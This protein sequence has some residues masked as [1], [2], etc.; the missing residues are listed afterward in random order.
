MDFFDLCNKIPNIGIL[1][2]Y[3]IFIVIIPYFLVYSG[4]L[5]VLKFYMPIIVALAH[6]LTRLDEKKNIFKGL[7]ELNPK[8]FVPFLSSNF[9]NIFALFGILWQSIE[10]SRKTNLT[11]GVIYGI[12]L[13]IIA[14]PFSRAGL[15]FILDNIDTYVKEKTDV[16]FKFNWHLLVFGLIYIIF[17]LG[18]QVIFSMIVSVGIEQKNKISNNNNKLNKNFEKIE[19]ELHELDKNQVN[20]F[21][22][23]HT[24]SNIRNFNKR[25]A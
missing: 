4:S 13:F 19:K 11:K 10:Y 14:L 18:L 9:I 16:E 8:E 23:K 20:N 6:L 17:I 12:L 25:L 15:K 3:L 21:L 5:N 22:K 1:L 7:Y 2:F 24:L